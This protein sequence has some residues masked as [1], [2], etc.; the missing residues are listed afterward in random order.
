MIG[1]SR[2][3]KFLITDNSECKKCALCKNYSHLYFQNWTH[4]ILSFEH[5]LPDF[6][7]HI[8]DS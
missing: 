5:H 3:I 2:E 7:Y 4:P 8:F 6:F 1:N